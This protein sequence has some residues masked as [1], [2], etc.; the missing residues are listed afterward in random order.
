MLVDPP[1]CSGV[2]W[3]GSVRFMRV[4]SVRLARAWPVSSGPARPHLARSCLPRRGGSC[5][6]WARSRGSCS[7]PAQIPPESCDEVQHQQRICA[8]VHHERA[9]MRHELGGRATRPSPTRI[10]RAPTRMVRTPAR[11][12]TSD[13]P[14]RH[15]RPFARRTVD[16]RRLRPHGEG[17]RPMRARSPVPSRAWRQAMISRSNGCRCSSRGRRRGS[18]EPPSLTQ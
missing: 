17:G 16:D 10:T 14:V 13:V 11:G 7:T 18:G 2:G 3:S 5:C 4:W 12:F 8:Q 15:M 1:V 6:T 9:L